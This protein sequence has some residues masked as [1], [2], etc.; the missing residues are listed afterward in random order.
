MADLITYCPTCNNKLIATT[1][2]CTH[3]GLQLQNEFQL[4]IFDY[5]SSD[6]KVF[7]LVFLKHQGNFRLL[8]EELNIS[9]PTAKKKMQELLTALSLTQTNPLNAEQEV[10]DMSQFQT[11]P[12][13]KKASE[14]IKCKI[15]ENGGRI[16]VSSV[17]GNTYEIRANAD[18]KSFTCDA[19]P[20]FPPYEYTVF[21]I[22]VQ[23]MLEQGG[24]AF[25]GMG[26]NHR[27][28]EPHCET[29]TLVGA[30]GKYYAGKNEGEWVFDPIFV[31]A[32]VLEW[33]DIAH[34]GRG[35][36]ELTPSYLLQLQN[37]NV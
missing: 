30:I 11:D 33:A 15:K 16:L 26:R 13:S 9:Y 19:L 22:M 7:L 4:S 28:G 10:L 1:L 8:Q 25:K 31:L 2:S 32:S 14:I 21:D 20:I 37:Q 29:T 3:C 17:R 24:K 35:Y 5:L 18:G 23:T 12:T 34:N 36:M 6:Q 27:L